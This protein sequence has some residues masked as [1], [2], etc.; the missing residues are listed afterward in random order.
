MRKVYLA[1]NFEA[2]VWLRD[3]VAPKIEAVGYIVTSRWISQEFT[4][5][6]SGVSCLEDI[7]KADSLILFAEQYGDIPG[8]AKYVELGFALHSGKRCIV[9]C[10][11]G[12]NA[13]NCIMYY[14]PNVRVVGSVEDAI[15]L[16]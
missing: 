11:P 5:I 4:D 1:H 10:P 2:R 9:V 8:R 13:M 12:A 3:N 15:P 14:L 7:T 16:I 6:V